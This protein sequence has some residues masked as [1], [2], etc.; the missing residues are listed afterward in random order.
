MTRSPPAFTILIL[1]ASLITGCKPIVNHF[2]F[3]PDKRNVIAM[4]NLPTGVQEITITTEDQVKTTSLYLP[5][6]DSK[7]LLIYFHGNAGNIYHRI[8]DLQQLQTFGINVIGVSYRGYGKSEGS[9]SEDGIYLDGKAIYQ[10]AIERLGFTTENIIILGRSI[11]STVATDLAQHKELHGLILV[12]PLSNGKEQAKA[13]GL[14]LIAA[15]AGEAFDNLSKID[16]LISPL[17]V[18]HG[19]DDHVVP[20][21]MG[22]A[23]YNRANAPKRFVKIDGADHNNLQETHPEM[24]WQP[25]YEFINKHT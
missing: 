22:K 25:I 4:E 6:V 16:N 7:K 24:Y 1:V 18:I 9:P 21:S 23:I 17:L 13:G 11:G 14:G 10:Y 19:T 15:L 20:F 8:P 2:A 3:Y 12:T 5:S